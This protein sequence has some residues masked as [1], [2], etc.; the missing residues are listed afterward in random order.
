MKRFITANITP[1][2]KSK[3]VVR[4]RVF[5]TPW[6]QT[7]L[8]TGANSN[9]VSKSKL[10]CGWP[11]GCCQLKPTRANS[12]ENH[13]TVWLRPR[14]HLT[15]TEQLG[16]SRPNETQLGASWK[17][18]ECWKF[19]AVWPGLYTAQDCIVAKHH[20]KSTS[21]TP[22]H[23]LRNIPTPSGSWKWE[24]WRLFFPLVRW[25]SYH[26]GNRSH[27]RGGGGTCRTGTNACVRCTRHQESPGVFPYDA[28][29]LA[30]IR[31]ALWDRPVALADYK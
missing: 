22:P 18:G 5:Q 23:C 29:W 20:C 2:Q 10:A 31:E 28:S 17:L 12:K 27:E 24:T 3:K 4:N 9:Q 16:E 19:C 11:N 7:E 6:R 30:G 21:V 8:P 26:R 25:L 13:S 1:P 15:V 14:G